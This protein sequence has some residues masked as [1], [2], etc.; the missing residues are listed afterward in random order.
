MRILDLRRIIKLRT[1]YVEIGFEKILV[2]ENL[3]QFAVSICGKDLGFVLN[4]KY[5][6]SRVK[7]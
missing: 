5:Q 2:R 7:L 4:E 1:V 6:S 3:I